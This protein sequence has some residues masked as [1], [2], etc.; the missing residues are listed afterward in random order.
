[1]FKLDQTMFS[2]LLK[3]AVRVDRG[4]ARRI[5][6]LSLGQG[7][8][9]FLPFSEAHG[10]SFCYELAEQVRDPANAIPASDVHD[11]LAKNRTVD[12]RFAPQCAY[13]GRVLFHQ[14]EDR[15]MRD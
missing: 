5:G 15:G 8:G 10:L 11:P 3:N 13:E 6:N 7:H 4:H 14:R 12:H 1:M 9:T 2:E